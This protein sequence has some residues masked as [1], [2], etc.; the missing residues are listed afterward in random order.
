MADYKKL[1]SD[2]MFG[3]VMTASLGE[4]YGLMFRKNKDAADIVAARRLAIRDGRG[5]VEFEVS[6]LEVHLKTVLKPFKQ[7]KESK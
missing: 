4:K 1:A 7:P 6:M 3:Q 2:L 5:K